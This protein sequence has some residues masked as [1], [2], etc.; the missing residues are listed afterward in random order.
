MSKPMELAGRGRRLTATL[1]DAILVPSLSIVL[2]MIAGVLEDAEDYATSWWMLWVLLLAIVSYLILNGYGLWQSGQTVGKRLLGIAITRTK[3]AEDT[4]DEF[5]PAPLWRLIALR[6][7]FFPLL[8]LIVIP[9]VMLIPIV[10]QLLIFGK[11]RRCLHDLIAGT[12][13][14][15]LPPKKRNAN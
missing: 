8:F 10:D 3:S 6:A 14:V 5:V 4:N 1:I 15:R 2:I 7:L 9:W 13:V 11:D 12:Q